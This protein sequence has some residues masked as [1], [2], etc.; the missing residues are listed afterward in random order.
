M[1]I[2]WPVISRPTKRSCALPP[3][4]ALCSA[5]RFFATGSL[6]HVLGDTYLIS[7][8]SV[9]RSVNQI[10]E[11]LVGMAAKYVKMPSVHALDKVKQDFYS[12]ASKK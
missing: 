1:V 2:L 10:A 6:L 7:P 3:L 12:I 11:A 9:C 5:L 4:L 8:A